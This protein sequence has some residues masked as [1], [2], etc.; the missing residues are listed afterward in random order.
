MESGL[1]MYFICEGY[2]P[3]FLCVLCHNFDIFNPGE[4]LLPGA[5]LG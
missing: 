4:K 2:P 3:G 1:P 5:D